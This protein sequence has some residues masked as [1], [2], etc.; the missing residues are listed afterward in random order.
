MTL[1][2][3]SATSQ[4]LYGLKY[5]LLMNCHKASLK[6]LKNVLL[7]KL[8]KYFTYYVLLWVRRGW[9]YIPDPFECAVKS[10]TTV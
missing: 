10:R 1:I 9:S 4:T 8:K 6:V 2:K 7:L 5:E 3:A